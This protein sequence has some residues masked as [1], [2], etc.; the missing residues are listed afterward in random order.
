MTAIDRQNGHGDG[1]KQTCLRGRGQGANLVADG[2]M[3]GREKVVL[4][5]FLLHG[6]E[7]S[8]QLVLVDSLHTR[9]LRDGFADFFD[10]GV[11][12]AEFFPADS[13]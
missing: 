10:D 7:L 1:E 4:K 9:R 8:L 3:S 2:H 5:L 6:L 11:L 12:L 13:E